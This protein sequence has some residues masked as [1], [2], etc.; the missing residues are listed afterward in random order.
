MKTDLQ[1]LLYRLP[2]KAWMTLTLLWLLLPAVTRGAEPQ[3]FLDQT[4]ELTPH[5]EW[6]REIVTKKGGKFSFTIESQGP[7]SIIII[8]GKRQQA[9]LAKD[10]DAIERSDLILD[11][12]SV[13]T[14]YTRT[15]TV[16]PGSSWFIIENLSDQNVKMHLKCYV[17]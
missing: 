11:L 16:P 3:V 12:P 7:V 2:M 5:L 8:S 1:A 6:N 15:V 9:Q 17:P 4:K 10:I 13:P 14:P